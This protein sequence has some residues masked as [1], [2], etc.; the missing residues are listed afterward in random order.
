MREKD[1]NLDPK[2]AY[3]SRAAALRHQFRVYDQSCAEAAFWRQ[4][5]RLGSRRDGLDDYEQGLL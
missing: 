1:P 2:N 4:P 3:F 5:S